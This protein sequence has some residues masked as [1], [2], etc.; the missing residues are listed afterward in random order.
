MGA[1]VA[2]LT[3]KRIRAGANGVI[4][5]IFGLDPAAPLFSLDAPNDRLDANDAVYTE[6][7]KT[8]VGNAGFLEPISHAAF[9][10]NGG[11]Y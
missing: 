2:G 1:H 4:Q 11:K 6:E 10:P 9:Y 3:G 8:N 7:I 5:V